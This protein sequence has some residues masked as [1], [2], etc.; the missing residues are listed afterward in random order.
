MASILKVDGKWR[1]QV[2]RKG[3]KSI[4]QSFDTKAEAEKWARK[5]EQEMDAAKYYD[6][7]TSITFAD[8]CDQYLKEMKYGRTAQNVIKH[9]RTGF[10]DLTLDKITTAKISEYVIGRGYSASTATVELSVMGTILKVARVVWK[11]PVKDGI[12]Q[13]ARLSLT[14]VGKVKKSSSRDRRPTED[15]LDRLRKYFDVH[16]A[17][18]MRDIIDFGVFTAMRAS[19]IPALLWADLNEKDKT[20]V[21]RNRKDP[22]EKIGNDQTVP[23]LDNAM[24]IIL[25]Q[26]RVG[27]T[28]FKHKSKTVSSIWPRACA[29]LKIEDLHFHDLRHEGISRLFEMGYQIHEVALFSGHKDWAMLKRYTQLRAKDLRRLGAPQLVATTN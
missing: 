19:E 3:H 16:S 28:I 8:V 9:L 6:G 10:G 11:M 1:A 20:I 7:R 13:D 23:L 29:K 18:P 15:E 26:P 14:L 25:R 12:V 27:L 17:L 21:I 5:L 2:R 24:A 4:A 22:K